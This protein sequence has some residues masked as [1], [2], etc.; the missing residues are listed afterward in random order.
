MSIQ[1]VGSYNEMRTAMKSGKLDLIYIH[2]THAALEGGKAG[3][4]RTLAWSQGFTEHKVSFLCR[5]DQL[6][7]DWKLLST[8]KIVTPDPD[9]FTAV[10]EAARR[11]WQGVHR[12]ARR[13]DQAMARIELVS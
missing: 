5:D 12:I 3:G 2:P 11:R 6:L 8:R 4:W 10:Q 7:S 13:A 1:V 9:S